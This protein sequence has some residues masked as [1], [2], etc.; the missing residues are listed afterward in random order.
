MNVV[1]IHNLLNKLNEI[2]LC[3]PLA[4]LILIYSTS[5]INSVMNLQEY[6]IRFFTYPK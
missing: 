4:S 2:I 3:E 1:S 6:N 5:L